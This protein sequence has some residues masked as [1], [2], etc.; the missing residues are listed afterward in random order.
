MINGAMLQSCPNRAPKYSS[1]CPDHA[2]TL[3]QTRLRR[4]PNYRKNCGNFDGQIKRVAGLNAIFL[5][6]VGYTRI[7]KAKKQTQNS[8]NH[9]FH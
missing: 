6:L 7:T 4:L 8:T 5:H 3:P 2:P 9:T 1:F